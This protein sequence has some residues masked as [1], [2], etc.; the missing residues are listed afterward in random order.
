MENDSFNNTVDEFTMKRIDSDTFQ[1]FDMNVCGIPQY[2][3]I[4]DNGECDV[5]PT[6]HNLY[7]R[8]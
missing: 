8:Y 3:V 2:I 4:Y 1:S 7:V 6:P 5:W